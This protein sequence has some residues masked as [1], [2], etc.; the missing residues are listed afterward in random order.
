MYGEPLAYSPG[1]GTDWPLHECGVNKWDSSQH[2]TLN[3]TKTSFGVPTA[4]KTHHAVTSWAQSVTV[5]K[6]TCVQNKRVAAGIGNCLELCLLR[7]LLPFLDKSQNNSQDGTFLVDEN[8]S[9]NAGDM[10]SNPDP[11]RF[12]TP[13]TQLSSHGSTTGACSL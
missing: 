11:G 12:H 7:L 10:G 6:S 8:P 13:H 3:T 1:P 2:V 4:Q 9:A 5:I